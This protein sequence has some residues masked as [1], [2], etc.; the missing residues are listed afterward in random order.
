M[1]CKIVVEKDSVE[2]GERSWFT[3]ISDFSSLQARLASIDTCLNPQ[4][5]DSTLYNVYKDGSKMSDLHSVTGFNTFCKSIHLE[6]W[7]I[8]DTDSGIVYK[9][10]TDFSKFKIL[11]NDKEMEVTAVELLDDDKI[12]EY[13]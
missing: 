11:R 7:D 4:G 5:I 12:V 1:A 13:L 3:E 9:G 10:V 8:E 2:G 6:G